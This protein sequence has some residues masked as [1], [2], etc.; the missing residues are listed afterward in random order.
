MR[1]EDTGRF[2]VLLN[3][4]SYLRL[5]ENSEMELI[6]TQ[7]DSLRIKMI[8]GSVIIEATGSGDVQLLTEIVTPHTRLAIIRTGLYRINVV[9][10]NSTELIVYKGRAVIGTDTLTTVKGGKRASVIAGLTQVSK[11]DKKSQDSFDFWS[12]SRAEILIAANGKLSDSEL[13]HAI[14]S[15][16]MRPLRTGV[17]LWVYDPFIQSHTFFPYYSG[18]NSPYGRGYNSSFGYSSD[19]Y[20][21]SR[22]TPSASHPQPVSGNPTVADNPGHRSMR[23]RKNEIRDELPIRPVES[24]TRGHR[25][26][27]RHERAPRE[28]MDEG[29][30][31]SQRSEPFRNSSP[32]PRQEPAYTPPPSTPRPSVE[33]NSERNSGDFSGPKGRRMDPQR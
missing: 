15:S 17:G 9:P 2:E 28:R 4:G 20:R 30:Q 11:F 31:N 21:P 1:T 13:S 23:E 24:E 27:G 19:W 33:R 12:K 14:L 18:W 7:L 22:T 25:S 29:S 3:P 26:E 16:G 5:A 32:P 10:S 8:K 6:D